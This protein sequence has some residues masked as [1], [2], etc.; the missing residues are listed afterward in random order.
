LGLRVL[1]LRVLG[2][3]VLGLRV[4]G[5]RVLGLRVLGIAEFMFRVLGALWV[6]EV[7]A[8]ERSSPL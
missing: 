5:L 2:L 4:L 3:R 6:G 1:G 8:H 7:G